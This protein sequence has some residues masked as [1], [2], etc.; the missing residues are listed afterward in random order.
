[1]TLTRPGAGG[2][3]ARASSAPVSTV[4]TLASFNYFGQLGA[5]GRGVGPQFFG[6][7]NTTGRVYYVEFGPDGSITSPANL[8][9]GK[10]AVSTAILQ[11]TA[12]PKFNN[13]DAVRGVILRKTGAVAMVNEATGF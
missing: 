1:M 9:P 3:P 5:N 10:I 2:G 4:T 8:N 13:K 7:T 6:L 11:P 12:V